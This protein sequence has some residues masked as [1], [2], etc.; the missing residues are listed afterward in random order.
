M[1]NEHREIQPDASSIAALI[2]SDILERIYAWLAP[3]PPHNYGGYNYKQHAV[4]LQRVAGVNKQWRAAA[5]P[6]L[7]QTAIVII[8]DYNY[9]YKKVEDKSW[10]NIGLIRE[11][12]Q[13]A[14]TRDMHISVIGTD[15][16]PTDYV[17][18]LRLAGFDDTM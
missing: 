6:L 7:Y 14:Y 12:G 1:T 3:T 16:R 8:G 15:H 5:L 10:T 11:A 18:I 9:N 4:K 2:P 17:R 13:M